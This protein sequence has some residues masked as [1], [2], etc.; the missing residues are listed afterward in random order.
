MASSGSTRRVFLIGFMGAGKTT[1]GRALASRL[2]WTFRDL[3]EV[4]EQRQGMSIAAIFADRGENAFRYLES[5]ALR[6]LLAQNF[7]PDGTGM[8]VA[9]G[10]GAFVQPEN[11]AAI[12]QAGA[13]TILLEA[14]LEELKRRIAVE[15]KARPL[16]TA[17]QAFAQLFVLRQTTYRLAQHRV[18]TLNKSIDQVAAEIELLLAAR[19]QAEVM[20]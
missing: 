17:D 20:P 18:Q 9:L 14:P 13:T 19:N 2:G 1:V 15:G 7:A 11:R 4:V 16:A 6:E 10:G 12:E 3:D 5:I 8:V